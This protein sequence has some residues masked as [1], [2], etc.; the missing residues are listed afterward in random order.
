MPFIY[1]FL[2]NNVAFFAQ[3]GLGQGLAA[4]IAVSIP[5]LIMFGVIQAVAG[6]STYVE[7]KVAAD[8]QRRVGPNKCNVGAFFGDWARFIVKNGTLPNAGFGG[9]AMATLFAPVVPVLDATDKV[10]GKLAPGVLIFLAD[11]IKLIMK[12]DIIP[13]P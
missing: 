1:Y 5:C 6:G 8:I 3:P 7:R 12:E 4:L 9:R 10:V 13:D 11:G 2:I